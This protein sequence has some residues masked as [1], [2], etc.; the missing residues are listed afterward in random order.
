MHIPVQLSLSQINCVTSAH[1]HLNFPS[2]KKT[3]THSYLN[4]HRDFSSTTGEK[5]SHLYS[6]QNICI[7]NHHSDLTTHLDS[8]DSVCGVG[9]VSLRFWVLWGGCLLGLGLSGLLCCLVGWFLCRITKHLQQTTA[10]ILKTSCLFHTQDFSAFAY[11][12]PV[13]SFALHFIIKQLSCTGQ[14]TFQV[15][16]VDCIGNIHILSYSG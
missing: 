10:H 5:K 12:L 14:I 4:I 6:T 15:K 2:M 1:H 8:L 11:C 16:A 3:I 7:Q 13:V 9:F